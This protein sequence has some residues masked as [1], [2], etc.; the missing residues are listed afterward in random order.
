MPEV[1]PDVLLAPLA[2]ELY[3]RQRHDL[4]LSPEQIAD[5]LDW[6]ARSLLGPHPPAG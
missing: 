6:L 5:Q 4:G 2:A 1:L 3:H